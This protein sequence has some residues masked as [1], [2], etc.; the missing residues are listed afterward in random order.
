MKFTFEDWNADIEYKP[1]KEVYSEALSER[2][3]IIEEAAELMRRVIPRNP[4]Y[5]LTLE[6]NVWLDKN[7]KYLEDK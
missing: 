1:P 4:G 2:D 6:I 5:D 3:A 7:V